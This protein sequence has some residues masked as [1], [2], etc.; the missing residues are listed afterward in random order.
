MNPVRSLIAK[1]PFLADL[2]SDSLDALSKFAME[3]IFENG[4][5]IFEQGDTA[6][7]FY[8]INS[9][10]VLVSSEARSGEKVEIEMLGAGDVLG[11]SWLFEP[12]QWQFDAQAVGETETIFFYATPL[13]A[14]LEE[15]PALGYELMRRVA[16]ITIRRLQKTREKLVARAVA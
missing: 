14:Y 9:G 4:T 2:D 7:R 6:S 11:W 16:A 5:L 8:L 15:N 1:H 12:F 10:N 3:R 13:L